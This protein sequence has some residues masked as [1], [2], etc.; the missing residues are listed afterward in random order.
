[1][2]E[3]KWFDLFNDKV[4]D[5]NQSVFIDAPIE[6]LPLFVKAGCIIP[7]QKLTESTAENSGDTLFVH[8][9]KGAGKNSFLYYE[10]DGE[11]YNCLKGEFYKRN[12]ILNSSEN[13]LEFEKKDGISISK[14]KVIN[15]LMHGY[16]DTELRKIKVNS[17]SKM[18]EKK[19]IRL[20][21][22]HFKFA[23][24]GPNDTKNVLS[25]SFKND[26][27]HIIINW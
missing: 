24:F 26:D 14:F 22:S 3:G 7:M 17:I 11:T 15:L 13:K 16:G 21:T 12:I 27:D 4:Y 19:Q 10:D 20:F 6:K 5:G 25:I 9:Y 1:M 8:I 2:P 23:D 18:T